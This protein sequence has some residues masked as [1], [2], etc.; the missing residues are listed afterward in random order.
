M[1]TDLQTI[2][3]TIIKSIIDASKEYPHDNADNSLNLANR[4]EMVARSVDDGGNNIIQIGTF[5]PS[6]NFSRAFTT[7]KLL[8]I[9]KN[10]FLVD[11]FG[12][13]VPP[14]S[15]S[16]LKSSNSNLSL[17]KESTENIV[18][19]VKQFED[20]R[21]HYWIDDERL[22]HLK[23]KVSFGIVEG[24]KD[25]KE[26]V[27]RDIILL[28]KLKAKVICVNNY[29]IQGLDFIRSAVFD[30]L[31]NEHYSYGMV[32]THKHFPEVSECYLIRI[33]K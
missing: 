28:E 24:F 8:S 6:T 1:I 33:D 2:D 15:I 25:K 3:A 9:D 13:Y 19:S 29:F 10:V 7:Q 23:N 31:Q 16:T 17:V 12:D 21:F 32:D 5:P 4:I 11:S 14:Y 20:N 30:F 26:D 18:K 27:F 22:T